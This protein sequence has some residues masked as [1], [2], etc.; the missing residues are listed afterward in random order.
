MIG[1]NLGQNFSLRPAEM[2]PRPARRLLL[3]PNSA[4]SAGELTSANL[5]WSQWRTG[6]G[7]T[8]EKQLEPGLISRRV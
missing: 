8:G 5:Q 7:V 2:S 6:T 1:Q 3:P 4:S